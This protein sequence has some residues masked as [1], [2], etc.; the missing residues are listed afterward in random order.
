MSIFEGKEYFLFDGAIGTYYSSKFNKNTACELANLFDRDSIY[1]IHREYISAGANAI[2][3]NTFGAN[4]FSLACDQSEADKIIIKGWEIAKRAAEGTAAA[5]FA[6]IGPLPMDENISAPEEYKKIVD[7]FIS[8]GAE[9]FLFETFSGY[10]ILLELSAYIR[11]RIPKAVIIA[12]FAVYPDGYTKEGLFYK[13]IIDKVSTS[14]LADACGL[15]CISGPAHMCRLV[16]DLNIQGRRIIIMPNSGYPSS[17]RGRDLFI[18]NSDYFAEK[19]LDLKKMGVQI[20]GG[21]CGTTPKHIAALAGLLDA[22][23]HQEGNLAHK[24][25]STACVPSEENVLYKLLESKKPI[26]VEIDPPFDTKWEYMLKDAFLL[27]QAGADMITIADSPLAKARADSSIL[28]SKIYREAGIPV[29]PH[30]TC[31]DKNLLGIKAMLLGLHIEGIRNI[32]TI[33]G[34]PIAHTERENI[35]GVFSINSSKLAGYISSL[36]SNVFH[37]GEFKIGGALNVNA[38]NFDA[39]LRRSVNKIENGIGYF[40]TQA[41]YTDAGINNAVRAVQTL[42]VPVF[43]G[44][45]PLV[46]YKNA[47]FINN[48]VPGIEIDEETI[49][50]FRDKSREESERIGINFSMKSINK[51]YKHVSGFYLMTPLKRTHVICELIK[52]IREINI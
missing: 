1:D 2:K 52:M 40:L 3:S 38:V 24:V 27:K 34:D 11:L 45:M 49:E 14:G 25:N 10:D 21:C 31:R 42:K 35:K 47:Q 48:E 7:I 17:E 23:N 5:V 29:M 30:I 13:D 33:T 9:N 19:I 22:N 20:L 36:N 16:K 8:C 44:I 4:R 6:D 50:L 43:A 15:N 28:A 32:L 39:E 51:L 41:V 18:D 46:G 12:S 37:D 26:L